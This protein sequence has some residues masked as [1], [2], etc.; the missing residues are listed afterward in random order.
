MVVGGEEC[1]T[2][3]NKM[4]DWKLEATSGLAIVLGVGN[5][6]MYNSKTG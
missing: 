6:A 3:S 2:V 5:Y 4:G 1:K